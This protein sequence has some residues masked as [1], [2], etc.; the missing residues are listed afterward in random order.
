MV[1]PKIEF[2]VNLA[3]SAYPSDGLFEKKLVREPQ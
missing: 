1:N 2:K 3:I